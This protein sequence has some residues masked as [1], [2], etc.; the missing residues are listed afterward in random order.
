MQVWKAHLMRE[1]SVKKALESE[2]RALLMQ[3][4]AQGV[5]DADAA[6]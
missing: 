4:R 2:P 5:I 3:W 6:K 1:C